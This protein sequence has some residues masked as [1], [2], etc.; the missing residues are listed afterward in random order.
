[1]YVKLIKYHTR[2]YIFRNYCTK[3]QNIDK[4]LINKLLRKDIVSMRA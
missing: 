2:M 1:M 3:I 4:I